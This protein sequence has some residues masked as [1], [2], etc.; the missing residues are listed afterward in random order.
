YFDQP[1]EAITPGQSVVVYDG[2]VVVGGG[3]I[4]EAIK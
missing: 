2:D 3:I 1:Q 4:R